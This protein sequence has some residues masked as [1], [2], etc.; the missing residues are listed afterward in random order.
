MLNDDLDLLVNCGRVQRGIAGDARLRLAALEGRIVLDRLLELI[1][2]LVGHVVLEHVQNE[3]LL[4]CL[5][6]RVEMEGVRFAVR[7]DAPEALQRDVARS[8][9]EGKKRDVLLRAARFLERQN[10]V[11]NI[12]GAGIIAGQRVGHRLSRLPGLRGMRLIDDHREVLAGL[13]RNRRQMLGAELLYRRDD[14]PRA[15]DDRVF[16]IAGRAVDLLH[17]AFG[18]REPTNGV[19]QLT[20]Q[21]QA[22]RHDDCCI[23]ERLI[24]LVMQ[25]DDLMRCPGDRIRL[26]GPRTVLD[27]VV[28]PWALGLR[29]CEHLAHGIELLKAWEDQHLFAV[30]AFEV[31][32]TP[33]QI[34]K[35]FAR[36]DRLSIG[37]VLVEIGDTVLT[38]H[39]GITGAAIAPAVEGEEP[40]LA[41]HQPR[42]HRH[43]VLI[44]REMD[45]GTAFEGQQRFASRG[46]VL[47]ILLFGVLD[48]LAG[49]QVLHFQRRDRNAVDEGH[50]INGVLVLR[51]IGHLP[52]HGQDIRLVEPRQI[53][54]KVRGWFEEAQREADVRHQLDALAQHHMGRVLL[55]RLLETLENLCLGLRAVVI[56]QHLPCVG[57]RGLEKAEQQL[58]VERMGYVI[59]GRAVA[60][61]IPLFGGQAGDDMRLEDLLLMNVGGGVGFG[62]NSSP[63]LPKPG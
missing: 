35:H 7:S 63:L 20:V 47:P 50:K 22:I 59:I 27:Q 26:A 29:V 36:E 62:H 33:D 41:V 2:G 25:V 12:L 17:H 61:E 53:R 11:L 57:L 39:V 37:Q 30:A 1:V 10:E 32:E 16:Q 6:H 51:G 46:A 8:R 60:F 28:L 55:Q 44:H 49:Q 15:L 14:D 18:L 56:F 23:E 52:H 19:L 5:P 13:S 9:G 34:E 40:R 45:D 31:D 42:G 58:G 24:V 38:R 3:P 43:V 48:V 4:D 21:H 54:V